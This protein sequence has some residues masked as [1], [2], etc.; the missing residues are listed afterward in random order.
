MRVSRNKVDFVTLSSSGFPAANEAPNGSTLH[1]ID[2]EVDSH[3]IIYNNTWEIDI[4]KSRG[5]EDR[6]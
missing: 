4:S 1:F 5:Y 6:S 3:Y 2:A